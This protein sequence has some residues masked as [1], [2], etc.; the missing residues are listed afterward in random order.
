MASIKQDILGTK[1]DTTSYDQATES[2][3]CWAEKGESRVVFFANVHMIMEA[4]DSSE[5]QRMVNT[6]DLV[7][8]DGMPLV[9]LLRRRGFKDQQRVSGY[10]QTLWTLETA[11]G[12]GIPVGFLGST[13]SNLNNLC[14]LV[15]DKYPDLK[16]AYAYSPP[17]RK[18]SP[19][20]EAAMLSAIAESGIRILFVGLGCPKQERWIHAHRGQIN[21]VMLGIGATF[22]ILGGSQSRAPQ[23]MRRQGL[24]W[25]YRLFQEPQRLW[26]RYFFLNPRFLFLIFKSFLRDHSR[27]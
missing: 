5:F 27:K 26:K 21:A 17:F 9:W 15:K 6:A 25:L 22:E 24:E 10:A 2:I 4:Y 12:S 13:P 1:I 8:P 20:E 14:L 3:K 23:W 11:L 18:L 16:I 7:T 19:E